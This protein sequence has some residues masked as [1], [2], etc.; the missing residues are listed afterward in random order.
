MP[1]P[2]LP[3]V[4]IRLPN[5]LTTLVG[6]CLQTP[7]V[8]SPCRELRSQVAKET[9]QFLL[10]FR[11]DSASGIRR[12]AHSGCQFVKEPLELLLLLIR[13]VRHGRATIAAVEASEEALRK[14]LHP[15]T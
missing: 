6:S 11:T 7:A 15:V 13:A 10:E 12:C 8:L 14:R 4:L 3:R 5:K 1:S 9:L 2:S